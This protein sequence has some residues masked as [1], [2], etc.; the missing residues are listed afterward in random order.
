MQVPPRHFAMDTLHPPVDAL[1]AYHSRLPESCLATATGSSFVNPLSASAR[2]FD[3]VFKPRVGRIAVQESIK[4]SAGEPPFE[5]SRHL[6][7]AGFEG[8]DV[9]CEVGEREGVGRREYLALK[10]GEVDLDLV[11]PAG[12]DGQVHD[13]GVRVCD[14]ELVRGGLAA[15]RAAIVTTEK[16][17]S[18]E[19]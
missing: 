5:G 1:Q 19:R 15:M 9:G 13:D 17:R 3:H 10:D 2:N 16:T 8:E 7:V 4:V 14:L 12:M 6:L 18:A 11:E